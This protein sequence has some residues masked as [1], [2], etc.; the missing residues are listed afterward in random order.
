MGHNSNIVL[1]GHREHA[2]AAGAHWQPEPARGA[3][4][5]G[6]EKLVRPI[7]RRGEAVHA[8]REVEVGDRGPVAVRAHGVEH[9]PAGAVEEQLG[10]VQLA[11]WSIGAEVGEVWHGG[12]LIFQVCGDHPRSDNRYITRRDLGDPCTA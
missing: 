9:L 3:T 4:C 8:A 5:P 12:R 6:R 2:P 1:G 10:A 11:G 7:D